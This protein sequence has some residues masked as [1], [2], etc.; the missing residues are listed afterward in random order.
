MV[1]RQEVQQTGIFVF[2]RDL[3][4]GKY[5]IDVPDG[6]RAKGLARGDLLALAEGCREL[7]GDPG[8]AHLKKLEAVACAA[9]RV[10]DVLKGDVPQRLVHQSKKLLQEAL[11]ALKEDKQ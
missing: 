7:G 9:D 10:N 6:A 3:G 5:F 4:T 1:D 8:T 2:S 11:D